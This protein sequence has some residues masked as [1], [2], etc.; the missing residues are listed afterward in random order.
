MTNRI[1]LNPIA[2]FGNGA[3]KHILDEV[4]TRKLSKAFIVTD[5]EIVRRG[6][7]ERITSLLKHNN[8]DYTVFDGVEAN[9]TIEIVQAGVR[10]FKCSNADY[11]IAVGGGSSIDT[12]KA[13]GIIIANPDF[14]DVRTLE[15]GAATENPAIPTIAVPTTAGTAA[16]VTINY[17]ITDVENRRK[18]VCYDP[19]SVPVASVIDADMMSSMPPSLKAATGIDALTHA[20]EGYTTLGAWELTDMFHKQAIEL[21]VTALRASVA[22]DALA[23]EDMAL[24]QYIAGMGFSNVGLGLVHGMAHPLSVF[25][26]T[27]HGVANAVLL[28]HIMDWNS[29]FTAE[30]YRNIAAAF[31]IPQAYTMPLSEVRREAVSAVRRLNQDIGIPSRLREIGMKEEDVAALATA[32]LADI[33]TGGNP[34]PVTLTDIQQLYR[35]LY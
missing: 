12:A 25:Y 18:F 10:A 8:L 11:M 20:I 34:R 4:Q 29:E 5:S 17:V 6:V 31:D 24:G 23:G 30:K 7:S 16:E 19:H 1:V 22:G 21:I 13:I 9:P 3:I 26:D 32:A 28:P 15:G 35:Q 27:P 33:C 14:A 2:Y